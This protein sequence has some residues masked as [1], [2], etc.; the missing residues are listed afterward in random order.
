MTHADDDTSDFEGIFPPQELHPENWRWCPGG[1]RVDSVPTQS[2]L[3][4][5]FSDFSYKDRTCSEN[6][7]GFFFNFHIKKEFYLVNSNL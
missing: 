1:N 3:K 4:M 2:L 5:Y 7:I 6:Y